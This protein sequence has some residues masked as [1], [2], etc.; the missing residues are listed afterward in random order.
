MRVPAPTGLTAVGI[1]LDHLAAVCVSG[2]FTVKLPLPHFA[3]C[4]LWKEVTKCGP[5]LRSGDLG[6]TYLKVEYLHKLFRIHLYESLVSSLP[7]NIFFNYSFITVYF[8][9]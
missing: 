8:G 5:H 2:V 3:Y 1:D 4:A 9:L 7:F 6:C